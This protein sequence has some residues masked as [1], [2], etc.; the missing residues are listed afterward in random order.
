M[1]AGETEPPAWY[2]GSLADG[3]DANG[4]IPP[5][6]AR[7]PEIP[8]GSIG[9]RMGSG[10]SWLML[11]WR[12]LEDQ[13]ADRESR[14]DYLRRHPPAPRP[15]AN[16]VASVLLLRADDDQDNGIDD[17]L[18]VR[19]RSEGLVGDDVAQAA[20]EA[21][22]GA[23]PNAPWAESWSSNSNMADCGHYGGRELTF[24]ARWCGDQRARGTLAEWFDAVPPA[25][26]SWQPMADA[27]LTGEVTGESPSPPPDAWERLALQIAAHGWAPPPWAFGEEPASLRDEYD[28]DSSY[29][30][31]WSLWIGESIDDAATWAVY[32][33]RHGPI[34]TPWVKPLSRSVWFET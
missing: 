24:W 26:P 8:F 33:E 14:R 1:S 7:Y 22:R 15:W 5:P 16:A 17:A 30:D 21:R 6:W 3:L 31:A 23:K 19:L 9:W 13:P 4:D 10:E 25:P 2:T 27:A 32:L 28:D 12:W 11:W 18:V 29:A 20:W 34:P